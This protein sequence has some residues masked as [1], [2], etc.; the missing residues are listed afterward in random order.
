MVEAQQD[1]FDA[2]RQK[3]TEC[4]RP[5]VRN[6]E[7]GL[8]AFEGIVYGVEHPLGQSVFSRVEQ[9]QEL[10]MPA[11]KFFNQ[12]RAQDE[13]RPLGEWE[14]QVEMNRGAFIETGRD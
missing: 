6:G 10:A 13:S 5:R 7:R 9:R 12:K 14:L 4:G 11:R 3:S 1:V 8:V 2:E